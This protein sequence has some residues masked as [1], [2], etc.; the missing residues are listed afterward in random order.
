M[1]A[2][3]PE[4]AAG[5]LPACSQPHPAGADPPQHLLHMQLNA[6][7]DSASSTVPLLC[8][9]Q[10][11]PRHAPVL[12]TAAGPSAVPCRRLLRR[13]L[14][15]LHRQQ[16]WWLLW[17]LRPVWWLLRGR[18]QSWSRARHP[19]S[20]NCNGT[21]GTGGGLVS[22]LSIN[23]LKH[24]TVCAQTHGAVASQKLCAHYH[25]GT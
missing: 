5:V 12:L 21:R 9:R 22:G 15:L 16:T 6:T 23:G 20:V 4:T 17:P 19:K 10:C 11:A 24:V 1:L 7:Q 18:S 2:S 8:T 25:Q 3:L 14:G 13:P